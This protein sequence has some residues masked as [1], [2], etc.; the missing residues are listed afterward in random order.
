MSDTD[1]VVLPSPAGV[2][3]IAVTLIS[4]AEGLSASRSMIARSTF[5]LVRPYGSSSPGSMPAS[6]ATSVIGR[7]V[8]ACAISRLESILSQPFRSDQW[9]TAAAASSDTSVSV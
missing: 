8:A 5:A 1:V 6:A 3:V 4:F 2:G 9:L 7:S